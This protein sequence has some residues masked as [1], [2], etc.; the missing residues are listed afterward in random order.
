MSKLLKLVE[1][2][3]K[4]TT[5]RLH[6]AS[7]RLSNREFYCIVIN[8]CAYFLISGLGTCHSH[9]FQTILNQDCT[10]DWIWQISWILL[11]FTISS[12]ISFTLFFKIKLQKYLVSIKKFRTE[13]KPLSNTLSFPS[14][15]TH[16]KWHELA[17]GTAPLIEYDVW[18]PG[19][20]LKFWS[21]RHN[22]FETMTTSPWVLKYSNT[23]CPCSGS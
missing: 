17:E 15:T 23:A 2:I 12:C 16:K 7:F 22:S 1:Y 21:Y 6:L 13:M 19:L 4:Y 14:C 11:L 9:S 8:L 20:S 10:A 18:N 5:V 3:W